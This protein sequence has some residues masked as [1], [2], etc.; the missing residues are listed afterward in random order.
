MFFEVGSTRVGSGGSFAKIM[1]NHIGGWA[2]GGQFHFLIL[3][4]VRSCH[5]S[6]TMQVQIMNQDCPHNDNP[7]YILVIYKL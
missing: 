1:A 5:P 3:T 2:M 4:P 7:L 6:L